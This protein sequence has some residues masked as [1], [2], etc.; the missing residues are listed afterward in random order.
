MNKETIIVPKG[1]KYLT[2]W[3]GFSLPN[4]P[5]IIDKKLTGC[6]FTE[7]IIREPSFNSVLISPRK[8]L[9]E[10]KEAQHTFYEEIPYGGTYERKRIY[11]ARCDSEKDLGIDKDLEAKNPKI[12]EEEVTVDYDQFV[13]DLN[14]AID[15]FISQGYP[16]K[17]EV[18]YDSFRK[19]REVLEKRGLINSFY[20]FVDEFQSIFTDSKFKSTTELEFVD[21]VQGLQRLY[22]VSATPMMEEY[23]DQLDEFKNLPYIELDWEKEDPSRIIHPEIVAKPTNSIN[24]SAKKIISEFKEGNYAKKALLDNEGNPLQLVEA[25]ELVLYVNSIKN[26]CDIIK[27]N[28]LLPEDVNIICART[29]ENA[30]KIREAFRLVIKEMKDSDLDLKIKV[31]S[32]D[33]VI[34]SVS[35][36][37]PQTGEVFNKPITICTKTVYLGA[38]FYSSCA[39]SIIFS[40]SGIECL[41]VDITLD[42]PQIVGR[43]RSD[44]NPWKNSVEI[45]FKA[46]MGAG[47]ISE[48]VFESRRQDKIKR[49]NNLL[50][51]YDTAKQEARQDLAEEYERTAKRENY[52]RHYVAVNRHKG[53]SPKPQ[54]NNLVMIAEK[55]AYD[56]QQKDYADRFSVYNRIESVFGEGSSSLS[57]EIQDFAE[58]LG[59]IRQFPDKMRMC[60]DLLEQDHDKLRLIPDP[61]RT[62]IVTLGI[63]F[64]KSVSYRKAYLDEAMIKRGLGRIFTPADLDEA[65]T[66]YFQVGERYSKAQIKSDLGEIYERLGVV[67]KPKASDLEKWFELR[68]TQIV[69]KETGKR[70][71]GFE[72]ISVK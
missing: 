62:Y 13:T 41:A 7:Y 36:P 34:G 19:L 51:A 3:K 63:E 39:R 30:K 15:E 31:P 52:K 55:R 35:V 43:Q 20:F 60:C 71:N 49:T 44:I 48:E 33:E 6:G 65:V 58:A 14:K 54:F 40:D 4:H 10:N 53:K 47:E 38:D 46:G 27:Q 26:I 50:S 1:I 21:A 56:I 67:N 61:F 23:L 24:T 42:L 69:N 28:K 29:T 25:R 57:K 59:E 68:K 32:V 9:L 16:I 8:S 66:G 18:T 64:I 11:Y 37:D 17:L 45:Y 2:E 70:D 12:L 22:F 5:A 72:I